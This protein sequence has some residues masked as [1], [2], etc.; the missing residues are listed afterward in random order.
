MKVF[1]I[2][3][4]PYIHPTF[5]RN[6]AILSRVRLTALELLK[7][8]FYLRGRGRGKLGFLSFDLDLPSVICERMRTNYLARQGTRLPPTRHIDIL[9]ALSLPS[10]LVSP[11]GVLGSNLT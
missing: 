7:E 10:K 11:A 4:L 9:W 1:I 3:K 8:S 6:D 5:L 2:G